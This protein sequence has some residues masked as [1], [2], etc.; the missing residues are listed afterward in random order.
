MVLVKNFIRFNSEPL[1]SCVYQYNGLANLY[2]KFREGLEE[3]IDST[4]VKPT[5]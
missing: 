5:L 4:R 3:I 2:Y 1:S